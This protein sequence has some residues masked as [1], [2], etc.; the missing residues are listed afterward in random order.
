VNHRQI[1]AVGWLLAAACAGCS[2]GLDESLIDQDAAPLGDASVQ[3]AP[4]NDADVAT[5]QSKDSSTDPVQETDTSVSD[6]KNEDAVA[7]V[8]ADND[9]GC[10]SPAEA[11]ACVKCAYAQC[12]T[13]V[14]TCKASPGCATGL[15]WYESCA[16]TPPADPDAAWTCSQ[17]SQLGG[18]DGK[19]LEDCIAKLCAQC[20]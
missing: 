20:P 19:N 5:E 9:A 1:L 14:T 4:A 18:T 16:N 8:S 7:D 11:G 2:L 3:D 6:A 17:L 13:L 10:S 15:Q 12:C